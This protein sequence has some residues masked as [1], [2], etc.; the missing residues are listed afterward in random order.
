MYFG[1]HCSV[2]WEFDPAMVVSVARRRHASSSTIAR[3]TMALL[4]CLG[5]CTNGFLAI[6]PAEH[7]R[8]HHDHLDPPPRPHHRKQPQSQQHNSKE[9]RQPD[10]VSRSASFRSD[11][12]NNEDDARSGS[13]SSTLQD[14]LRQLQ[15]REQRQDL[16]LRRNWD[17]GHWNQNVLVTGP[18]MAT[19]SCLLATGTADDDSS[20]SLLFVGDILGQIHVI[21]PSFVSII[22]D[23]VVDQQRR[24]DDDDDDA[25][26][27][28]RSTRP[29]ELAMVQETYDVTT[30]GG[31]ILALAHLPDHADD[32]IICASA[33][34]LYYLDRQQ[35]PQLVGV[36]T[37]EQEKE[38]EGLTSSRQRPM[39]LQADMSG[40]LDL[41]VSASN[42]DDEDEEED[43]Q[44]RVVAVFPNRVQMYHLSFEMSN[45]ADNDT[46]AGAVLRQ[47]ATIVINDDDDDEVIGRSSII[48]SSAFAAE[49]GRLYMGL[50]SGYVCQ[51]ALPPRQKNNNTSLRSECTARWKINSV[52]A[53]ITAVALAPS[54]VMVNGRQEMALLL[55]GDSTGAVRQ[56]GLLDNGRRLW[57]Q[58]D[59]QKLPNRAH[60]FGAHRGAIVQIVPI[61]AMHFVSCSDDGTSTL[62]LLCVCV[63]CAFATIICFASSH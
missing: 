1:T 59:N 43:D 16:L 63:L 2:A 36:A 8:R 44:Y 56:W 42:D 61:D 41:Y 17:A 55:T 24:D 45:S 48:T 35:Q 30:G 34:G 21:T 40:I 46:N 47:G 58:M 18:N 5:H 25:A 50:S 7:R 37:T 15:E 20:T 27:V 12:D 29:P 9:Q 10:V 33:Q 31:S 38:E 52:D 39:L 22:T 13:R 53:A 6:S 19:I 60:T 4:L 23:T 54:T 51:Y 49:S 14:R 26:S 32:A 3:V 11:N 28:T 62:L 57:P